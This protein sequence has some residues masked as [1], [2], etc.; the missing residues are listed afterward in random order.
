MNGHLF[1]D[2]DG[3]FLEEFR[4]TFVVDVELENI[5]SFLSPD[6]VLWNDILCYIQKNLVQLGTVN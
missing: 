3:A 2:Q 5:I 4:Q 1:V 6:N